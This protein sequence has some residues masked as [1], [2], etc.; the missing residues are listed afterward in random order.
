MADPLSIA[1][2]VASLLNVA[3]RTATCLYEFHQD[4]KHGP[5]L[6]LALS[7]EV[8]D[9]ILVLDRINEARET[10]QTLARR[11]S[12]PY[13]SVLGA[14]LDTA[15]EVLSKL[16]SLST[17]LSGHKRSMQRIKW[18]LRQNKAAALKNE[19]REVR[20]RINE[21]MTAHNTQV[22]PI[23]RVEVHEAHTNLKEN[24]AATSAQSDMLSQVLRELLSFRTAA[25]QQVHDTQKELQCLRNDASQVA[26]NF[27][28]RFNAIEGAVAAL[29]SQTH[30]VTAP[31]R[32]SHE[33]FQT[34]PAVDSMSQ[35]AIVYFSVR[36]KQAKCHS[37]CSCRCHFPSKPDVSWTIPS[38]LQSITG[39]LFVGYS[40]S[41]MKKPGC[42][43]PSCGKV[44]TI[45]L[46]VTYG[47][48]L[49]FIRGAL[50]LF[51]EASV[52]GSFYCGLVARRRIPHTVL[53]NSNIFYTI[54]NGTLEEMKFLLQQ[55]RSHC[56]DIWGI[57]GTCA[58]QWAVRRGPAGIS[59]LHLL[60]QY[61]ADPDYQDDRGISARN[62]ATQIVLAREQP[63]EIL[64]TMEELFLSSKSFDE[65]ELTII[66]KVI[67]GIYPVPLAPIVQSLP[68]N[69]LT[70]VLNSKDIFGSTALHYAARAGNADAV[71][72]LLAAGARH[73]ACGEDCGTP[74]HQVARITCVGT[75]TDAAVTRCIDL[76]VD[77]GADIDW[78]KGVM[79]DY[80]PL[81]E[82]ARHGS[83]AAMKPLLLRGANINKRD[84]D[85]WTAFHSSAVFN[86]PE[87]AILLAQ[88]G[89]DVNTVGSSGDGPLHDAV[90]YNATRVMPVLF[91]LGINHL[92]LGSA[93][94]TILHA[95]AEFAGLDMLQVLRK[96]S[97]AGLDIN[98]Q[99][100]NGATPAELFEKRLVVTDELREAFF[101]LLEQ[102]EGGFS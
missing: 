5:D 66:H 47:F 39:L 36:P 63:A 58:L 98:A 45:R 35:E 87:A 64:E 78:S 81:M 97:L 84:R 60:L 27:S 76:L 6:I 34:L 99:D 12:T 93:G 1:S 37:G 57:D 54:T 9:L 82:A 48:P 68:P 94:R 69:T 42:D 24:L 46:Q 23:P 79:Y 2:G 67:A 102:A 55:D 29:L 26:N 89:A 62:M 14:Q 15:Q 8:S 53:N 4:L 100:D 95:A 73:D 13:V 20:L 86:Q 71:G 96:Q 92:A 30:A 22:L 51:L 40:G 3:G 10:L 61:G 74:L 7:N 38:A 44:N 43:L 11:E 25:D 59:K 21:I 18:C 101:G 70:E 17:A 91:E 41:P 56:Q 77:A 80:T 88:N 19:V 85:N 90:L 75:A 65:L 31:G 83:R 50:H 52:K 32:K 28:H 49:W 72:I 33:R 16:E